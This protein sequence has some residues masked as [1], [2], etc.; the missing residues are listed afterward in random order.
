MA[1]C[2]GGSTI[3]L[4]FLEYHVSS[5]PVSESHGYVRVF[6][7]LLCTGMH[8]NDSTFHWRKTGGI[9]T[10][11]TAKAL[12]VLPHGNLASPLVSGFWV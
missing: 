1:F 7:S 4:Q 10:I 11:Y 5:D 2:D 12:Q 8:K 9:I 3:P 6:F